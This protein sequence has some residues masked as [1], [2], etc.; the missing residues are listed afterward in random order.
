MIRLVEEIL[1]L[2]LDEDHGELAPNYPSRLLD[3]LVAG[4]VLMELALENRIDTDLERLV[5]ADATP[6]DDDLLDPTLADVAGGPSERDADYWL[7]R[8]AERAREIRERTTA[9]LVERGI[10]EAEAGGIFFSA[11]VARSRRYPS[12]G[13]RPVEE[14][15]LRIM[16]TLFSDEI[17]G[18]R[19]VALICL[20]DASGVLGR[21]LTDAEHKR[22]R[23][24]VEMIR[25]LDLI[26]RSLLAAIRA[27]RRAAEAPPA[28]R[29]ASEIPEVKGLPILGS[30]LSMTGDV[31]VF[32]ARQYS[33]LGP[34]FR[35]RALNRRFIVLAG[36]EAVQFLQSRGRTHLRQARGFRRFIWAMGAEQT[37]ANMEGPAHTRM[38]KAMAPGVSPKRIQERMSDVLRLT[39]LEVDG[40]VRGGRVRALAALQRLISRQNAALFADV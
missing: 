30:A 33:E 16:R 26:G 14:V 19:D 35:L 36:P 11:F 13:G 18:P 29:P 32:F 24:R 12:H 38:R 31:S 21:L 6:L 23:E 7:V 39:R 4:A 15:R 3:V 34:C 2:V 22:L 40:W 28:A 27:R 17:P 9:R 20:S 10:L 1:L 5:L 8:T 37:I 25:K